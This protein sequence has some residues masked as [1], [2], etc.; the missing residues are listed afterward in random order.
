VDGQ[1]DVCEQ[2]E[3]D[4]QVLHLYEVHSVAQSHDPFS[5]VQTLSN[6]VHAS[7]VVREEQAKQELILLAYQVH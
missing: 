4:E 7:C 3:Q 1:V 5:V 2:D 6:S